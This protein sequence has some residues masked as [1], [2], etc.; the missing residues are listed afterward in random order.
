MKIFTDRPFGRF[1]MSKNPEKSSTKGN[2]RFR[3]E[4]P[5]WLFG[6]FQR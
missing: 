3:N 1:F 4:I 2:N 6:F 5:L